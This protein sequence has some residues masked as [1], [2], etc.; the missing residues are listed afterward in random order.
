MTASLQLEVEKENK[1]K[2]LDYEKDDY[3][4]KFRIKEHQPVCIK[5]NK[6]K[7]I[8]KIEHNIWYNR[9]RRRFK[10]A[11]YFSERA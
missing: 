4:F 6:V 5:E 7:A 10:K 1:E 11:S 2:P 3:E 9:A 8:H